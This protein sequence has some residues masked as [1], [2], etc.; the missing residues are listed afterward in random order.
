MADRRDDRLCLDG[1]G[2]DVA[3]RKRVTCFHG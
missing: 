1:G 2:L 3:R